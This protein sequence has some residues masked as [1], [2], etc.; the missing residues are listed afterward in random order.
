MNSHTVRSCQQPLPR[1]R[2]ASTA[3]PSGS[4]SSWRTS[5]SVLP[6]LARHPSK[7]V[8]SVASAPQCSPW[9]TPCKWHQP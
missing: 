7:Q 9:S 1:R 2:T 5:L 8:A 3:R 6:S 4:W